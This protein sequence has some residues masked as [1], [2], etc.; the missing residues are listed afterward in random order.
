MIRSRTDHAARLHRNFARFVARAMV[1]VEK[2]KMEMTLKGATKHWRKIPELIYRLNAS[3]GRR[4][5]LRSDITESFDEPKKLGIPT[6]T[7]SVCSTIPR[8]LL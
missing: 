1:M 5:R 4:I 7:S 6:A 8:G 3:A 2:E